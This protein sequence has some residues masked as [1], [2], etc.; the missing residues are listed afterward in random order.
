MSFRTRLFLGILLG[1]LLPL[2][3]LAYGVQHEMGRRL[4]AEYDRRLSAMGD[5]VASD[6]ARTAELVR[7]RLATITADLSRDNRFRRAAL[8]GE[9]ESR[10]YL[11]D[12]A[13]EAM[14]L[15]GLSMLQIQDSSGRILSSGHFRNEFDRFQPGL[16]ALLR[17]RPAALT[18]VRTRTPES[19][20]SAFARV[21]SFRVGGRRFDVVGGV[22]VPAVLYH[23][24]ARD[25]DIGVD[26]DSSGESGRL[27]DSRVIRRIE[28]PYIDLLLEREAAADTAYVEVTQSLDTLH[29]LQRSVK[30]WFLAA[31]GLTAALA[32]MLAGWLSSRI[33]RPVRDLARKTADID[34]DRLDQSFESD[35]PDEIGALSR[36]LGEMTGRLRTSSARLREAERRAAVG[37]LA[38]QVN[39]DI[40]NGLAPIRNVLRHFAQVAEQEPDRLAAVFAERKGTLDASIEYLD[41]LARNYARLSPALQRVP[42][43]VNAVV[44]R[45]L[46]NTSVNGTVLQAKLSDASPTVVGDALMLRRILENLVGNAVDSVAGKAGGTVTVTTEAIG[47]HGGPARVRITVADTGPGMTRKQLDQAFDDFYTTK[48]E[49]TGLGLSI[50]RR[51]ILDLTGTL[52]VETAPGAG[53]SVIIELPAVTD[54]PAP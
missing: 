2:G 14:N 25:P 24:R 19:S 22:S 38:Q 28:L 37:E 16:P 10:R 36:L 40:K 48:P 23:G 43:D 53:T 41:T 50:V 51:L 3:A 6:L 5:L 49:G 42:C 8:Q 9:S 35:R 17:S 45:V 7:S 31:S 29:N 54:G 47:A 11:L 20:L 4:R 13:G 21:D 39:H 1:A 52:R 27:S 33:S 30:L 18:L 12:Y 15:S 26:L 46:R 44:E 34:L 32:L